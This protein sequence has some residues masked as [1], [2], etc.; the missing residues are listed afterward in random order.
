MRIVGDILLFLATSL[1]FS[2]TILC[3]AIQVQARDRHSRSFLY[4]LVPLTLQLG[5]VTLSSY[6]SRILPAETLNNEYF[7]SFSQLLAIASIFLISVSLY[8]V[9]L[10]I[11][12]LARG[13]FVPWLRGISSW[14]LLPFLAAFIAA[15]LISVLYM[16]HGDWSLA[17][18]LTLKNYSS[19]GVVFLVPHVVSAIWLLSRV[20]DREVQNHLRGIVFAFAPIAVAFPLD[21]IYFSDHYFK[22]AYFCFAAFSVVV[23]WHI[24][25]R[26]VREYLPSPG[27]S[28]V[29]SLSL[30]RFD[31]SPR[32]QETALLLMQGKTNAEIGKE[33]FISENTVRSHIK[34]IYRKARVANRVQLIHRVRFAGPDK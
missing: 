27:P 26:F 11:M 24:S 4:I 30:D 9:G 21:L 3:V 28:D 19:W 8:A 12:R 14:V 31:L 33:L 7:G 32:E 2:V 6:L 23:Y 22:L 13:H 17:V 25:K 15:S 29:S 18:S 5:I 16:T 20:T 34:S 10:Y 1:V